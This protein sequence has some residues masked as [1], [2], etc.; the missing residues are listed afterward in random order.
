MPDWWQDCGWDPLYNH[1]ADEDEYP[2]RT[3]FSQAELERLRV[4]DEHD[5][6][7]GQHH[8]RMLRE[9]VSSANER[10]CI[11]QVEFNNSVLES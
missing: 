10:G 8:G 4:R 6:T 11:G 3:D 9:G 1:H 5:W 7:D 2:R